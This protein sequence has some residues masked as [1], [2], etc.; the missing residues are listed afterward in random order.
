[1]VD[2]DVDVFQSRLMYLFELFVCRS[3]NCNM[4]NCIITNLKKHMFNKQ[5]V[6]SKKKCS[7]IP[8]WGNIPKVTSM[9]PKLIE[10]TN[11]IHP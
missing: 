2:Y 7:S 5:V 4:Y 9:F 8:T 3:V 10:T 11:Q 6:V 1:M